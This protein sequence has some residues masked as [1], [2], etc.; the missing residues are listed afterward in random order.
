MGTQLYIEI[1]LLFLIDILKNILNIHVL[2]LQD[3][4]V[5]VYFKKEEGTRKDSKYGK[6]FGRRGL[7]L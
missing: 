3:M 6:N 1:F 2:V 7:L 4:N 5:L